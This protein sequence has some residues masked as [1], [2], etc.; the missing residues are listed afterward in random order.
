MTLPVDGKAVGLI[1]VADRIKGS[2]PAALVA[3]RYEGVRVG[4]PTEDALGTAV[5]IAEELG[6][7]VVHS[8]LSPE[9]KAGLVGTLQARDMSWRWQETA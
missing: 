9:A 3:L 1:D 6:A 2:T 8:G 4:M 7:E 5:V